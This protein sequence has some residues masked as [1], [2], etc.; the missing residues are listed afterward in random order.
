[1]DEVP[2]EIKLKLGKYFTNVGGST[3]VIHGLP[4]ELTGGAWQGIPEQKP[5]YN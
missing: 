3:F 1:M 4:S 2:E 5:G